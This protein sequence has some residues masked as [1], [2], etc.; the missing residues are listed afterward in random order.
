MTY[1]AVND[2]E[3]FLRNDDAQPKG[4]N[5]SLVNIFEALKE[6]LKQGWP[7]YGIPPLDPLFIRHAAID[8]DSDT[9]E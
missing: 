9:A 8:I 7:E 2:L 3:S 4:I 1:F 5:E 6:Y